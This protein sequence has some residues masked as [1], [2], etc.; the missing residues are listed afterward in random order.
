MTDTQNGA[1]E[2]FAQVDWQEQARAW[3][4][5]HDRAHVRDLLA[6]IDRH[7][8]KIGAA[9]CAI[10]YLADRCRLFDH[11]L[12]QAALDCFADPDAP[13]GDWILSDRTLAP[14]TEW[15]GEPAAPVIES[16]YWG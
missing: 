2:A 8:M 1:R 4:K 12:I 5:A 7:E 10:G 14:G 13:E 6:K 3:A 9:Y 16:C 15:Q 11:P